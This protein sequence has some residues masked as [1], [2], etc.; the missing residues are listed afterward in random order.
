MTNCP[1]SSLVPKRIIR[2]QKPRI[3]GMIIATLKLHPEGL[4]AEQVSQKLKDKGYRYY[5]ANRTCA[6]LL[7]K[8][9]S[10]FEEL[11]MQRVVG[12]TGPSNGWKVKVYRLREDWNVDREV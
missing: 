1:Y 4:S 12:L 9:K 2:V 8:Y 10:L 6:S 7:G 11:P 5:P 3:L